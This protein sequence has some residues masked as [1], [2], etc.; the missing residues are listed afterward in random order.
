MIHISVR[1]GEVDKMLTRFRGADIL[2]AAFHRIQRPLEDALKTYPPP[3][4]KKQPLKTARQRQYFFWA[5]RTGRIT[6]PYRRT[7]ELKRGWQ[8]RFELRG[9]E[10]SLFI[11][12]KA[13]HAEGVIGK[14]QWGYHKG[15]WPQAH[16]TVKKFEPFVTRAVQEEVGRRR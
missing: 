5:L 1:A 14:K 15:N 13:K 11:T 3:T 7:D 8:A 12:N 4:H 10:A 6:V 2:G 9:T 16:V